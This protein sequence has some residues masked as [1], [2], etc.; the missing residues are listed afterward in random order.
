MPITWQNA[1]PLRLSSVETPTKRHDMP[2]IPK[3]ATPPH[4]QKA[5][6]V[7]YFEKI[8]IRSRKPGSEAPYEQKR[9]G[10]NDHRPFRFIL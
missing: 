10:G 2:S 9:G 3:N 7:A 5:S 8:G 6:D 1:T 4:L